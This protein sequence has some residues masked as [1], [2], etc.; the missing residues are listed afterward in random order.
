ME[1]GSAPW[2]DASK[3]LA[4]PSPLRFYGAVRASYFAALLL[5]TLVSWNS[6]SS[7]SYTSWLLIVLIGVFF[8]G[9]LGNIYNALSHFV[10]AEAPGPL[11]PEWQRTAKRLFYDR[12]IE[13]YSYPD[14]FSLRLLITVFKRML[15]MTPPNRAIMVHAPFLASLA[16][17]LLVA[18]CCLGSPWQGMAALLFLV[19]SIVL[20]V[21]TSAWLLAYPQQPTTEHYEVKEHHVYEVKPTNYYK[22]AEQVF[23]NI[24]DGGLRGRLDEVNSAPDLGK[25]VAGEAGEFD[26]RL[27]M[28]TQ[29]IPI[30][31]PVRQVLG[32]PLPAVILDITACI[33]GIAGWSLLLQV[34]ERA[35]A[36]DL[37]AMASLRGQSGSD[38]AALLSV[39]LVANGMLLAAD[40]L[41]WLSGPLYATYR[42]RS[43]LF[44]LRVKGDYKVGTTGL[45]SDMGGSMA[46][47]RQMRFNT[48]MYVEFFSVRLITE[49]SYDYVLKYG[50]GFVGQDESPNENGENRLWLLP[51]FLTSPNRPSERA[52]EAPRY[53]VSAIVDKELEERHAEILH[54]LSQCREA[55]EEVGGISVEKVLSDEIS[56]GRMK[57]QIQIEAGR[58]QVAQ[59]AQES[60]APIPI[61]PPP[62]AKITGSSS[63]M[64]QAKAEE[65]FRGAV[66]GALT[67]G[68]PSDSDRV[69][70]NDLRK[71]YG[72]SRDRAQQIIKE[73]KAQRR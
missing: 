13:T 8:V 42:F 53:L 16:L 11:M 21:S 1:T 27:V 55:G 50:G 12:A 72:L 30:D 47:S 63:Q 60:N 4:I 51:F 44:D 28:E 36:F 57:D 14:S 29:P 33:M 39:F 70:L 5:L 71:S 37:T 67:S 73:V 2:V 46:H 38:V 6:T 61:A 65:V 49:C 35:A 41:F 40:L 26:C 3:R 59:T 43:D 45:G 31:R 69:A 58:Q 20:V 62:R 66:R 19:C 68:T 10:P 32:Q 56:I 22:H 15:F 23:D 54:A 18:A 24:R 48:D 25:I 7:G 64:A 17:G 9:T 34:I 52:L